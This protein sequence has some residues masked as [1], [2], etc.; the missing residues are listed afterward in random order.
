MAVKNNVLRMY[1]FSHDH[2]VFK[3]KINLGFSFNWFQIILPVCKEQ[4]TH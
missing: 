2:V 4:Q 3:L 1:Q